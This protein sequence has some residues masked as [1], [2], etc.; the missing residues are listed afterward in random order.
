MRWCINEFS[1]IG[2]LI[3]DPFAGSGTILL[4]AHQLG[5]RFLG[6]ERDGEYLEIANRRL[7]AAREG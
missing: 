3:L 1:Q 2:D 4:A 7:L 5:R 6:I